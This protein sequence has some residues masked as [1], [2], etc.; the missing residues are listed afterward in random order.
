MDPSEGA[1]LDP[2]VGLLELD[3][4]ALGVVTGDAMVK[5]APLGSIYA[6]TVHPGRYL[7]LVSGDT[8]SVEVSLEA[9]RSAGGEGVIDSVFLPDI[10][11]DVTA[12][13]VTTDE[14]AV[15]DGEAVGVLETSTVATVIDAADAGVKAAPVTIA[16]VRLADGLGGKG[17]VIFGGVLAEVEAAMESATARAE[18]GGALH[19]AVIVPQLAAEM[20][21]N[22]AAD[23]RFNARVALRPVERGA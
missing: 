8:A 6:G 12:A 15:S 5:S 23:L 1:G 19:Q 13:I 9:G 16:T 2:A 3:S 21:Q 4:V 22:L 7:I 17:Y 10:H 18:P 14:A 11:P 20:R